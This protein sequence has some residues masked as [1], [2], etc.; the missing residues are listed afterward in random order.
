MKIDKKNEGPTK[1]NSEDQSAVN[2][3]TWT[4]RRVNSETIDLVKE[5]AGS[6]GMK[7]GAWVDNQL[8]KAAAESLNGGR[9]VLAEEVSSLAKQA[10]IEIIREQSERLQTLE[11]G[12]A[13]VLQGQH[14]LFT[15]LGRLSEGS[16]SFEKTR[17]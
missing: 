1:S 7:I 5:A 8:K 17:V 6:E 12:L 15:L 13:K 14:S 16:S 10:N 2:G 3:K 4:I 9:S 11:S